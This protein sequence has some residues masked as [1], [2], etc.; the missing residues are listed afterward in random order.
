MFFEET[1]WCRRCDQLVSARTCAHP[2]QD[3]VVF[4]GSW[5]RDRLQ[6]G[7]DIP[8][9][10]SR[11]EIV[12]ILRRQYRVPSRPARRIHPSS[13]GV[14]WLTGISGAGKSTLAGR[15]ASALR[16]AGARVEILDGDQVR[17]HLS[18][19]LGF[20]RGDR[21]ENIRR[22]GYVASMV[23]AHGVWSVVAAIS[24]YAQARA[25]ARASAESRGLSFV[26][27]YVGCPLDVAE[28]RDPKGLYRKARAGEI[29]QF[30]AVSDP[31]EEPARPDLS[32][33]TH[34]QS[35]EECVQAILAL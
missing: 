24:P 26:E 15:L 6:S 1:F 5:I 21:D 16:E 14:I 31:Y 12:E 2:P 9:V 11:P 32:L 8:A 3:R 20:S 30:T 34:L 13:G 27:V 19:G 7:G 23:A 22:I 17:P 33:E 18:K 4:S 28:Q 35:P 10:C 25:E 29:Q